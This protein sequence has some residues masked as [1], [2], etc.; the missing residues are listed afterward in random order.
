MTSIEVEPPNQLKMLAEN[1]L[2]P[3]SC[4]NYYFKFLRPAKQVYQVY[5]IWPQTDTLLHFNFF[6][7]LR[8]GVPYRFRSIRS[9][10]D[11]YRISSGIGLP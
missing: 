6:T 1:L 9:S 4:D 8:N 7:I 10:V 3:F 11:L 2:L 5:T